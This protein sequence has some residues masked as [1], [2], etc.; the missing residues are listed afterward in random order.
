MELL[1]QFLCRRIAY[2]AWC[3]L[4]VE[5]DEKEGDYYTYREELMTLFINLCLIKPF[6]QN[7][8]KMLYE[9]LQET[10]LG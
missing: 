5:P 1:F 7:I 6:N 8:L 9:R 2:P 4:S 10:S 3:H